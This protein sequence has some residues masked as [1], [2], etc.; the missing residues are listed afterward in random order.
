MRRFALATAL[1]ATGCLP[2]PASP[3]A[4]FHPIGLLVSA[5]PVD[6]RI[7]AEREN[8]LVRVSGIVHGGAPLVARAT[9]N[10]RRAGRSGT[11]NNAQGGVFAVEPGA[12]TVVGSVVVNA[13]P[14]DDL[15]A[16][17][18]VDWDGGTTSCA[19]P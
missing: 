3:L 13:A 16:D 14:G 2:V 6:C 12:D 15:S 9:L 11:S 17:L 8:G 19:Y 10:V 5:R 1:V 4:G 18:T 7:D